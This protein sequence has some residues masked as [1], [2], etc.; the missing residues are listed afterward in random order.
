MTDFIP[1]APDRPC[2]WE[3]MSGVC[4]VCGNGPDESCGYETDHPVIRAANRIIAE[5]NRTLAQVHAALMEGK[6][7]EALAR[8]R[9]AS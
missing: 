9:G 2:N 6:V 3:K 4:M 1:F 8:I 7:D 5:Q